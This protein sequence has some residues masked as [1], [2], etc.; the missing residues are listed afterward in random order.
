MFD[1]RAQFGAQ[2]Q[3]TGVTRGGEQGGQRVHEQFVEVGSAVAQRVAVDSGEGGDLLVGGAVVGGVAEHAEG[4]GVDLIEPLRDVALRERH[5]TA[6][7]GFGQPSGAGK[8]KCGQA[9]RPGVSLSP[10]RGRQCRRATGRM[11]GSCTE[12]QEFIALE[13]NFSH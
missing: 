10:V 5:G 13:E 9:S 11:S 12:I 3:V 7:I 2:A 8:G 6:F 4:G 1:D